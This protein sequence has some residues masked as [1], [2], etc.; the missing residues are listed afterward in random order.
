MS[1]PSPHTPLHAVREMSGARSPAVGAVSS[2][3]DARWEQQAHLPGH[4]HVNHHQYVCQHQ[5]PVGSLCKFWKVAG[6]LGSMC[7]R[8][9][10]RTQQNRSSI[11]SWAA[12]PLCRTAPDSIHVRGLMHGHHAHTATLGRPRVRLPPTSEPS[13]H[14][15]GHVVAQGRVTRHA[16]GEVEGKG[17]GDGNLHSTTHGLLRGRGLPQGVLDLQEH[18]HQWVSAQEPV[19]KNARAPME[20]RNSSQ[21]AALI[22]AAH[23]EQQCAC[24]GRLMPHSRWQS[25]RRSPGFRGRSTR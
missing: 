23:S 7:E 12:G 17:G 9:H 18:L 4:H 24:H 6:Q 20:L 25:C 13:E 11:I 22:C 16:R 1:G 15:P 3:F 14:L 2:G 19:T 8:D 21:S 5:H 10:R